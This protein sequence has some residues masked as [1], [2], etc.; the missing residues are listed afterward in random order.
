MPSERITI[1]LTERLAKR[2]RQ[3][4]RKTKR[5]VSQ[6][7]AGAIKAQ[8]DAEIRERMIQGYKE[9]SEENVRLAEEFFP[10]VGETLPD[11]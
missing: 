10:I 3:E 5:P 9:C 4:A 6:V 8:E 7:I 11:D 2:V 1:T